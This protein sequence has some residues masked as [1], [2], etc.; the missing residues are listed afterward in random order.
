MFLDPVGAAM[1]WISAYGLS[2]LFLIAFSERF[3]PIMPSYGMLVAIGIGAAEGGGALL[4]VFAATT[5]GSLAACAVWFYA[6]RALGERRS[7][8]IIR[9][10]GALFGL[11][12]DRL[13]RWTASFHRNQT[14]LAFALQLVPTVR[15]FAPALAALLR[16]NAHGVL[17]A[18]AGGIAV[19]NGLFIGIGFMASQSIQTANTT[20][21][22]LK[23]L[24]CLLIAQAAIVWIVRRIRSA[25]N[26][27][28][29]S[30]RG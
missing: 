25:A 28:V 12:A 17:A 30:C 16:G 3:L 26:R 29:A 15:L 24:A 8:R 4:S 1:I 2:G 27:D 11:S 9:L 20:V 13:D 22:A 14:A 6:V 7:T 18:S 19:W 10:C 23:A 5:A 21:I